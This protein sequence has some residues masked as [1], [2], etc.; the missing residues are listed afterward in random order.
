MG[1]SIHEKPKIKSRTFDPV[2]KA[3]WA[4]A[5]IREIPSPKNKR[6]NW[7]D[8]EENQVGKDGILAV[9]LLRSDG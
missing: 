2:N 6:Q 4:V 9:V 5:V 7:R 1:I 3:S 8:P